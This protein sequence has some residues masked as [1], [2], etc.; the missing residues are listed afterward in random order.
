MPRNETTQ[1][2]TGLTDVFIVASDVDFDLFDLK[3]ALPVTRVQCHV[4]T[5]FEIT[6]LF[7]F[8]DGRTDRRTTCKRLTPP[9]IGTAA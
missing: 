2:N 1:V 7:R 5:K 9:H 8:Q 4:I 6:V 3:F